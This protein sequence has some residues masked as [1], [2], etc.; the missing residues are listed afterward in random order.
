MEKLQGNSMASGPIT[1]LTLLRGMGWGLLAGLA[2]TVAMDLALLASLP[3][4]G[5]PADT[6]Y[7][8][9]GSTVRHFFALLGITLAGDVALGVAAYHLIGPLLGA[10]YSLV[11]SQ[12][13]ALQRTTL[14]KNLIY[15]VLYAEMLSQLILTM[16]PVL[17]K[18]PAQETIIW[19]AGSFV[20]HMIW[21]IVM[22]LVTYY[23]WQLRTPGY[24]N[25]QAE[26]SGGLLWIVRR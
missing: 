21:G 7:L 17:L 26:K 15:A 4:L 19:F 22:G 20:V 9:I 12:V 6:C 23:G 25:K 18:M 1:S 10:L 14:K 16:T 8:I 3:A 13:G 11:V 5:V 2:G 24:R